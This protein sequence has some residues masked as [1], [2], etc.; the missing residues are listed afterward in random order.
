M[1][2][3][4]NKRKEDYS[5]VIMKTLRMMIPGLEE[6]RYKYNIEKIDNYNSSMYYYTPYTRQMS[7]ADLS[8]IPSRSL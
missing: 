6:R 7:P 2:T 3:R 5:K 8:D 1:I 4:Y